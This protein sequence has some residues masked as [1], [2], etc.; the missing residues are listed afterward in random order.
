MKTNK[1]D[2]LF[3][4]AMQVAK[5]ENYKDYVVGCYDFTYGVKTFTGAIEKT[6]NRMRNND[7]FKK[8]NSLEEKIVYLLEKSREVMKKKIKC[9]KEIEKRTY[10]VINKYTDF[11]YFKL[12]SDCNR[13]R[14]EVETEFYK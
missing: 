5:M 4:D 7:Y 14:K 2:D 8:D 13:I 3:Y 12:V 9:E 11:D 6:K 10:T 1:I